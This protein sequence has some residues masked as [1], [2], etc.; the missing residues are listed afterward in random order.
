VAKEQQVRTAVSMNPNT[1]KEI[2]D[3]LKE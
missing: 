1:P 3:K 2:L